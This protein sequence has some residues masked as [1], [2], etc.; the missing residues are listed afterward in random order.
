[1][2]DYFAAPLECRRMF[3]W[4]RGRKESSP[5]PAQE[6]DGPPKC[7]GNPG[8]TRNGRVSFSNDERSWNESFDILSTTARV[9][10]ER[11]HE[12]V[13]HSNWLD[14]PASGYIVRP[15]LAEMQ[16]VDE[17]GVR[18]LTTM[19]VR[20]P[21]LIPAGLFEYQ[22]STGETVE[23][24]L[25]KGIESWA[26][27]DLVVLLDALRTEPKTC[28]AMQMTFPA[29]GG[30]PSY[31]RRAVLGPVATYAAKP[32]PAPLRQEAATE[33][34]E[35]EQCETHSFC[36]CCFLTR[37][38]EA[39]RSQIEGDGYFGIR[40]YGMR[41]ADGT[42]GADCRING[43]DYEPGAVSVRR[44][45]ATWEGSGFEFRKQYVFLHTIGTGS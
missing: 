9:I 40:F 1:M 36:P 16:L 30:G 15:L 17:G 45:V 3:D 43:E 25:T 42:P 8:V 27:L 11:G 12:V 2:T 29:K 4:L 28:T 20:H 33:G 37:S 23:D 18:T 19:D 39:F 44:D 10:R 24:S 7:A 41:D 38:F 6:V 26:E 35:G 21:R 5:R 31:V 22:H 32:S 13:A 14:L 34:E